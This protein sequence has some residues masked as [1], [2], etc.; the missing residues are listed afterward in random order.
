MHSYDSIKLILKRSPQR[1]K[2]KKKIDFF[3]GTQGQD[4]YYDC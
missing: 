3:S 4:M 2:F 1:T